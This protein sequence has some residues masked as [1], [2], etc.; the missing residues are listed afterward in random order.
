MTDSDQ[1]P[2]TAAVFADAEFAENPE[3]RCPCVLLLDKS[4]SM[5]GQPI[6]ELN[7]GLVAFK[8]DLMADSL[9]VKRVEVLVVT[10]GPVQPLGDFQSPDV[11]Q[12]PRLEA[13]G[14]TPMGAA[15]ERGIE[16]LQQR[17][18]RYQRNGI[19]YYR[20]WIFLITDGAPTDAWRRAAELVHEG[21]AKKSFA[22]FAVGTENANF[23]TLR[24]IAVREPLKL[25]GVRFRDLFLWLSRSLSS[26]SRSRPGEQVPLVNP[27]APEGWASIA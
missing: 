16:L 26:V 11:F 21:E 13:S 7:E 20:P 5:A 27:T 9:A 23:E 25:K 12:P 15:I 14:D 22:F 2:L 24:Q 10:F 19:S 8:D 18:E 4:G 1:V 6:R 17:K 3:P